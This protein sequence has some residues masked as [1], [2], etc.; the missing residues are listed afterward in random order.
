MFS[1]ICP[2]SYLLGCDAASRKSI[3]I[4]SLICNSLHTFLLA[5]ISINVY[6]KKIILYLIIFVFVFIFANSSPNNRISIH[7]CTFLVSLN[8]FAFIFVYIV[9]AAFC[10]WEAPL[11]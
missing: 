3:R 8:L 10:V 11:V 4:Q 2:S 5:L 6:I 7:I 9:E 1:V